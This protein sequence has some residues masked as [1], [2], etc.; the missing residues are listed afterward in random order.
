MIRFHA[1]GATTTLLL[2]ATASGQAPSGSDPFGNPA[3]SDPFG[4]RV[5]EVRPA[6]TPR[7]TADPFASN[8]VPNPGIKK[9]VDGDS[10][11][12]EQ[13]I[14]EALDKKT[15][16]SFV[17]LPLTDCA[18]QLSQE[19]DIPI[20]IDTRSLEEI[21]LS[22]EEPIDISLKIV[23]LRSILKLMLRDYELTYRIDQEVMII[24]TIESA[25]QNPSVW[26]H[27]LPASLVGHEAEFLKTLTTTIQPDSWREQ[28]GHGAATLIGS[29]LVVST[30]EEV[31][32]SVVDL[33]EK[34]DDALG[35]TQ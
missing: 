21:G 24:T 31:H 11:C 8:K 10:L 18:A 14:R 6:N 4:N 22:R 28:G 23:S 27:R 17:E 9:P 7:V 12:N 2:I 1:L 20:M 16:I 32:T 35:A 15:S 26:A 3:G 29:V 30:T 5:G 34:A 25:E 13:R 19:F 33:I